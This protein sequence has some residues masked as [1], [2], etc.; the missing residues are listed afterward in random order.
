M[1]PP[2]GVILRETRPSSCGGEMP[3]EVTSETA[4]RIYA[5]L[6]EDERAGFRESA[7][8]VLQERGMEPT[9]AAV[10]SGAV[11][12]VREIAEEA[13]P[14]VYEAMTPE[15]VA[16]VYNEV[17]E[18]LPPEE[19]QQAFEIGRMDDAAF[20]RLRERHARLWGLRRKRP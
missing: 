1:S 18:E 14:R 8:R 17:L 3:N 11:E 12:A 10:E 2:G 15:E 19:R 4:R 9:D 16:D 6:P 7:R 13:A 20:E 5:A